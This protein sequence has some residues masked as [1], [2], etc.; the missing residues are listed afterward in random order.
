MILI[1]LM[2]YKQSGKDTCADYLVKNYG[3]K[4]YA[5]AE[6]LKQ[7][8]KI[9]FQLET[10]QLE[11][12][13]WK[14]KIDLRWNMTPRQIMQKVGT[15]MVRNVLGENFWIQNIDMRIKKDQ[16]EKVVVSDV[17]FKNEAEW[18]KQHHG[19]LVRIVDDTRHDHTDQ[20][21]SEIEQLSIQ[22][23]ICILNHKN[24]QFFNEIENILS[25]LFVEERNNDL[26]KF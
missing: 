18:I 26:K 21:S 23:D 8:C 4:K 10:R 6:P 2:G 11:D 13:E 20:H 17:R 19:V 9:M 24:Q 3:F 22:E 15:D 14:E 16:E 25:V 1:G 12:M 7:V 5:F